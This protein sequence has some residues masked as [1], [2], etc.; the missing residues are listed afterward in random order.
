V[1]VVGCLAGCAGLPTSGPSADV[2]IQEGTSLAAPK[3]QFIDLD[4]SMIEVLNRRSRDSFATCFSDHR[5]SAEP[6]IGIGDGISVTIW[7]ASSGGLFSAPV[8]PGISSGSNSATIPEQVVGRDGAITVPYAGRVRVAGHTTRAVQSV[9]EQALAG[10][11]IQPQVLVNVL[12]SVSN[13]V[14][15]GGEA[16]G[17]ARIPLS[18]KGDRLLDVIAEAGGVKV[19]VNEA[20]VELSRGATT[21]RVPLTRVIADP[22]ENISMQANDVLTLVHD[23]QTFLVVGAASFNSEIPFN[24]DG[25]TLAQALAKSGGLQDTRS[26][27][28]GVFIFRYEKASIARELRPDVQF[29][30]SGREVPIVYRLDLRNPNSLFVEQKFQMVNHDLIFVSNAPLVEA[31]KIIGIFNSVLSPASQSATVAVTAAAVH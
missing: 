28:Q 2:V 3:Y 25:I 1:V 8:I 9:I 26:D 31:E 13:T 30:Y 18:V 20:Y 27:P 17:G 19:P 29:A 21:A 12:H 4:D 11:A 15:V 16:I 7:E 5:S 23:P 14:S 24:S 10:K 22:R 6:L